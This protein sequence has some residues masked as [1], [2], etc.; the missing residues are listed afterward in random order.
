MNDLFDIIKGEIETTGPIPVARYMELA[1]SH[2]EHGYYMKQD[3]LGADGDFTTAPEI[4][5]M[6]GEIVGLWAAVVWQAMGQP[7]PLNLVELGPGRGT[8]MVDA[9][10][11][12]HALPDFDDAARLWLVETSP[13]LSAKQKQSLVPTMMMPAWRD[14]FED[15]GPGPVV[16]IANEFFDALP[17]HQYERTDDGWRER[18][19]DLNEEG[20]GLAFVVSEAL[21]DSSVIPADLRHATPPGGIFEHQ[22]AAGAVMHQIAARVVEHGGAALIFDYGHGE[23]G[24]GETVQAVKNHNFVD[25]LKDPGDADLTTHVNFEHLIETARAAGADVFGPVPQ[26]AFLERLGLRQ[27]ADMLMMNA[28]AEQMTE[29]D[30]AYNR[31]T[32]ADQMGSLFKVIA[33]TAPGFGVPPWSG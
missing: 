6:F 13:A 8:L 17:T 12:A 11:A 3:P 24:I 28:T 29:I 27:R 15:V 4:S 21:A 14:R 30:A 20:D 22:P 19:V 33:V 25:V 9:L 2:P 5:Q 26:G 31:L 10:R 7:D 18:Q 16:V 32:Q 23:H 1:L